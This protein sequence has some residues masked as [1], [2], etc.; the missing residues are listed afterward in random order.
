MP[1]QKHLFLD[2]LSGEWVL[3][4][5]VAYYNLQKDK[6]LTGMFKLGGTLTVRGANSA[7][8]GILRKIAD[9]PDL[10]RQ[11]TDWSA[12]NP[13]TVAGANETELLEFSIEQLVPA[14]PKPNPVETLPESP[15]AANAGG[16]IA[17]AAA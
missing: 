4:A 16:L 5:L 10:R 3:G 14:L 1:L 12:C 11:L 17:A 13:V 7:F 8:E 9:E 15:L 2:Y 6:R